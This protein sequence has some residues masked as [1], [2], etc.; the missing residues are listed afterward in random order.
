MHL[1]AEL[2]KNHCVE[3]VHISTQV[4]CIESTKKKIITQVSLVKNH[5][6][7]M[8][9]ESSAFQKVVV[10]TLRFIHFW[11]LFQ[12]NRFALE[13]FNHE[14]EANSENLFASRKLS[15]SAGSQQEITINQETG[16]M[17]VSVPNKKQ[18]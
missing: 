9:K 2:N 7:M 5:I 4:R 10:R 15:P 14:L 12:L 6:F 16:L 3:L 1:S 13:C 8:I 18:L 11:W 17:H